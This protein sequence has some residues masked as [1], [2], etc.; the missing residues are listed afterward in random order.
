MAETY[1]SGS[2]VPASGIYRVSHD[3]HRLPHEV[4]LVAEQ[5][6]PAC[7]RCG[8]AVLFEVLQLAPWLDQWREKIILYQ[9]PEL[10][11]A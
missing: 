11:V 8:D 2:R 10:D 6:F 1:R 9:L 5:T 4:T 3:G 7:A